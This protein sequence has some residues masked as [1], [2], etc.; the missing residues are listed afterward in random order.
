MVVVGLALATGGLWLGSALPQ[1]QAAAWTQDK[2]GVDTVGASLAPNAASLGWV[3]VS[4]SN[5]A[6]ASV[7][8][9]DD[10]ALYAIDGAGAL[11]G[12]VAKINTSD[13][14]R[15]Q[16]F[17]VGSRPT[18]TWVEQTM[19]A[20]DSGEGEG[21]GGF[22][23]WY[24]GPANSGAGVPANHFELWYYAPRASAP[25]AVYFVPDMHYFGF[26]SSAWTSGGG[27]VD[28]VNG[29]IYFKMG[30]EEFIGPQGSL[31]LSVF[32][33]SSMSTYWSG[34]LKPATPS[35]DLW[36]GVDTDVANP[37]Y[38][39]PGLAV[40]ASGNFLLLVRGTDVAIAA[41]DP[42]NT[43]GR[44]I[45]A[46]STD[47]SF[48]VQV[49]PSFNNNDWTYSVEQMV[50]KDPQDTSGKV[51]EGAQSGIAYSGGKLY[52]QTHASLFGIDPV[53]GYWT[54]VGETNSNHT[55]PPQG[56]AYLF[57]S[58]SSAQTTTIVKGRVDLADNGG[59]AAQVVVALYEQ[60]GAAA[61]KLIGS[62]S[63]NGNG[64]Y[65]FVVPDFAAD[66]SVSYLVRLV[67][68]TAGGDRAVI[69]AG[70]VI[71]STALHMENGAKL[72]CADGSTIVGAGDGSTV[73][74]ACQG[75]ANDPPLEALGTVVDPS[76]FGAYGVAT[77]RDSW[78]ESII[79]FTISTATVMLTASPDRGGVAGGE[80][81]TISGSGFTQYSPLPSVVVGGTYS[82][83]AV[84]VVDDTTMTCVM[85]AHQAGHVAIT[86]VIGGKPV[87]NFDYLYYTSP[88][89]TVVK[90]GWLGVPA[91]ASHDDIVSGQTSAVEVPTGAVLPDGTW[92]TWTYTVTGAEAG[93]DP[94][95]GADAANGQG[96]FGIVVADDILGPV[97]TI[98]SLA[99]N[100][101]AGCLA[102]G[103]AGTP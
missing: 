74:G 36:L 83:S 43:T 46:G 81:L 65:V 3:A 58:L 34:Q 99:P 103:Y 100:S 94:M 50:T 31:R 59:P 66:G 89:L 47:V 11:L 19:L 14:S 55:L 77:M 28:Q 23:A 53:T 30:L 85:P 9:V 73:S 25:T 78:S 15:V 91:G 64:G 6:T 82:C 54:Y 2:P 76:S 97:C 41:D 39:A 45:P 13:A 29:M 75:I 12:N 27:A 52:T 18:A 51:L 86:M 8:N 17:A 7:P 33:P 44:Y 69:T 101:S 4:S 10:T 21:Q 79:N 102:G 72:V 63:T 98:T 67:Q 92:V 96:S 88:K 90:R 37:G 60:R 16:Q 20:V 38:V 24:R 48:L 71:S 26:S 22:Y 62:T 42:V 68:P 95:A 49:H 56:S 84:T 80:T 61:P 32:D 5:L 1:A 93:A 40:T 70:S 87:M 35:D 57:T